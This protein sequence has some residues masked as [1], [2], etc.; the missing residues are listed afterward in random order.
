M[1]TAGAGAI[2]QEVSGFRSKEFACLV[3]LVAVASAAQQ[4]RTHLTQGRA[5]RPTPRFFSCPLA[6]EVSYSVGRAFSRCPCASSPTEQHQSA[7]IASED[8]PRRIPMRLFRIL[9]IVAAAACV[10]TAKVISAALVEKGLLWFEVLT[11]AMVD[12]LIRAAQPEFQRVLLLEIV[13]EKKAPD[14]CYGRT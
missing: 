11:G 5:L 6:S 7:K 13:T 8:S 1:P 9:L 12:V 10:T 3:S 14:R 4:P 2:G